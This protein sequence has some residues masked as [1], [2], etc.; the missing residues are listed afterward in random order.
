MSYHDQKA[1]TVVFNRKR[2][3]IR[4]IF[5]I[6]FL[7]DISSIFELVYGTIMPDETEASVY[8][9]L[10]ECF[11]N[12]AIH[13]YGCSRDIIKLARLLKLFQLRLCLQYLEFVFK[14]AKMRK[15]FIDKVKVIFF[16]LSQTF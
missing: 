16:L 6:Q 4:Y 5:S 1:D 13:H 9:D 15:V 8:F 7:G 2:I 3:A 10:I 12:Y 11:E 14:R